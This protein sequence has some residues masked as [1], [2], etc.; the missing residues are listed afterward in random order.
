MQFIII[1][2]GLLLLTDEDVDILL[3]VALPFA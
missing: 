3:S 1:I 2:I